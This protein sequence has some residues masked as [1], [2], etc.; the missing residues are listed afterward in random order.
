MTAQQGLFLFFG[1]VALIT[2]IRVVTVRNLFHAALWLIATLASV[3]A[4]FA[5]LEA[6]FLAVVQVLTYIGAISILIIFAIMLT[7]GMMNPTAERRLN[8]WSGL[9]AVVSAALLLILGRVITAFPWPE[10]AFT[11][12]PADS[13]ETLGKS[14]VDPAQFVLPFE[15]ASV[16]LLVA[17]VGAIYVA[18]ARQKGE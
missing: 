3:A 18:R 1:F 17:L 12:A 6:G 9:G 4:I 14:L 2:A 15:V 7:R 11:Q 13:I 5:L 16:L 8:T 10:A